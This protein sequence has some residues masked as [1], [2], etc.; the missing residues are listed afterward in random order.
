MIRDVRLD[1]MG[2]IDGGEYANVSVGGMGKVRGDLACASLNINGKA[3][4]LGQVA[5]QEFV[6]NGM[7]TC[8]RQLRAKE[9]RVSGLLK[10]QMKN[11]TFLFL[12][13]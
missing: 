3:R 7:A 5:A 13:Q 8:R 12:P 10:G 2:S 6:C 11:H 9:I 4:L 1:G